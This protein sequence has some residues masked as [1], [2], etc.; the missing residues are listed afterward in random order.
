LTATIIA[1][2]S[3]VQTKNIS[4]FKSGQTFSDC[5]DCPEMVVIPSGS[6]MMGSKEMNNAV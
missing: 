1:I 3:F 2:T 5:K 4:S 6:F